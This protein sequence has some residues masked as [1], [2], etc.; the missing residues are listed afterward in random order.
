MAT[1]PRDWIYRLIDIV[2]GFLSAPARWIAD[3]VF[4][5]F[6]DGVEFSKWLKS[7]FDYLR[8]KGSAFTDMLKTLGLETYTTLRWII[9]TR[10]PQLIGS[11]LDTARKWT[12][13]LVNI[14]SAALRGLISTLDKWTKTAVSTIANTLNA[15][16]DAL[17]A[18][19]NGLTDKLRR[20]VD[21]WYE[22]LTDPRKFAAWVIGAIVLAL[23]NYAYANR[24]QIAT[25]FL[26]SSPAFTQW[27]ARELENVLKRL[28]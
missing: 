26:R 14:T 21:T 25:W 5:V 24:D 28:L 2:P 19:I 13:D 15:V 1:N 23:L 4:G 10:V 17:V 11:A 16:R 22:R 20:T 3:R 6:D 8:A 7:G 12:T 9:Q 18:K 27:L